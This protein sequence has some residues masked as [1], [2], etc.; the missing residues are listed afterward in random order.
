[1]KYVEREYAQFLQ[2]VKALNEYHLNWHPRGNGHEQL[3]EIINNLQILKSNPGN[4]LIDF[5]NNHGYVILEPVYLLIGQT[6]NTA[7]VL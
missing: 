4:V 2:A 1:M 6:G 3:L 5:S 7:Q